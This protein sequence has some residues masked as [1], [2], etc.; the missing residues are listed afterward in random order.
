MSSNQLKEVLKKFKSGAINVL[1]ATNVIEEGLDVSECNNVI[2][3]NELLNVKAFI[4]MKGRARQ[5]NSKFMFLCADKE[6]NEVERDQKNFGVVIAKMK[7]LAFGESELGSIKPEEDILERKAP[8]IT[9][10]FCIQ[11]TGA[12]ISI[13]DS[14]TMIENFCKLAAECQKSVDLK[15]EDDQEQPVRKISNHVKEFE[16]FF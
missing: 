5:K 1:I 13:R 12:R 10:Y 16:P 8:D 4:Q 6:C 3:L 14:K 9:D 11:S 15:P 7:Q 2:C